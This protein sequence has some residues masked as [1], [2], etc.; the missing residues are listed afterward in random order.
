MVR[1]EVQKLCFFFNFEK[2]YIITIFDV[3]CALGTVSQNSF[4]TQGYTDFSPIFSSKSFIVLDIT[5]WS[6]IHFEF[7]NLYDI[8]AKLIFLDEDIQF[9]QYHL[10]K[11][12][13]PFL[14][15]LSLPPWKIS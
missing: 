9:S 11:K 13:H 10:L 12:S 8:S 15:E 5:L 7:K 4:L 1:F 14:I 6:M 3:V 2:F